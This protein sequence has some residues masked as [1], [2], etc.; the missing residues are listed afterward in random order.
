MKAYRLDRHGRVFDGH[1]SNRRLHGG[2]LAAVVVM[3][4]VAV[5]AAM[6]DA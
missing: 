4:L 5:A 2:L 6:I 3:F 1:T